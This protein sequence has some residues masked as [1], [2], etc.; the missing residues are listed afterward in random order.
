MTSR[1]PLKPFSIAILGLFV[2]VPLGCGSG[3]PSGI[4]S[5]SGAI[6]YDGKPIPRGSITFSPDAQ[7]NNQGP[8]VTAEI[9]DGQYET[10]ADKGTTGGPYILL[11][12]AYDGIPVVSG[13]GGMDPIGKPLFAPVELQV[14]LPKKDATHDIE[15]PKRR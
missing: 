6:T 5:V 15:I 11:V 3:K 8:G 14:D 2:C 1:Y 7:K 4:Y 12:Q 10:F 9:K 13:E